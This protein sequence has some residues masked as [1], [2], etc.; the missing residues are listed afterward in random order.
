M[1][2]HS[3]VVLP[4]PGLDT[5]LSAVT[6]CDS[7]CARLCAATRLF[8]PRMSVSSLIARAWLMPGTETRAAPA[9][10]C[11][12]PLAG[13]TCTGASVAGACAWWW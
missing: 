8:A 3:S 10:K 5:R 1:V 6:P 9:P 4:E 2:A 13:F 12:S 11:R 7:K